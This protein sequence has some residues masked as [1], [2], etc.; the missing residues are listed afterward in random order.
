MGFVVNSEIKELERRI[1]LDGILPQEKIRIVGRE[2]TNSAY[3]IDME[4]VLHG[5][6]STQYI[7]NNKG[8]GFIIYKA[9]L[10]GI[11]KTGIEFRNGEMFIRSIEY[12]EI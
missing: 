2:V 8:N 3:I 7:L 1:Y 12:C 9:V 11:V 10:L 4:E 6:S 5:N